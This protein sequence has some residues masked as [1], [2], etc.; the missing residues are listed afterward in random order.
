M[1]EVQTAIVAASGAVLAA[2]AIS[3]AAKRLPQSLQRYREI[4]PVLG[5]VVAYAVLQARDPA[6]RTFGGGVMTASV[7]A[8]VDAVLNR[9]GYNPY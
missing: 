3:E 6:A 2:T 7:M 4:V 8:L 1:A 9:V 5:M